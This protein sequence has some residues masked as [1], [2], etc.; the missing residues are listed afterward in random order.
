MLL[1]IKGS[2]VYTKLRRVGILTDE[3][4]VKMIVD[5]KVVGKEWE[6]MH[7]KLNFYPESKRSLVQTHTLEYLMLKIY[8][9]RHL[10][11]IIVRLEVKSILICGSGSS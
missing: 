8:N 4:E 11:E 9:G 1:N 2:I 5:L 6:R 10:S 3:E 7:G